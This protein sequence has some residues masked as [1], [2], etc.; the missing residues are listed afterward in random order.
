MKDANE[1]VE[2]WPG[3]RWS[4]TRDERAAIRAS[5]HE[6]VAAVEAT[7]R[8]VRSAGVGQGITAPTYFDPVYNQRMSDRANAVMHHLQTSHDLSYI[9]RSRPGAWG[10]SEFRR[11]DP[12]DP[13]LQAAMFVHFVSKPN[14]VYVFRDEPERFA[15]LWSMAWPERR[16]TVGESAACSG[17]YGPTDYLTLHR[18]QFLLA[19][20]CCGPCMEHLREVAEGGEILAEADAQIAA[21][22]RRS[23]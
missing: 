14:T 6:H 4:V 23:E 11:Y 13:D 19:W 7:E 16:C 2:L 12:H 22:Q 5:A 15:W 21:E 3:S 1:R 18:G 20:E 9:D 8:A 10:Y 17:L